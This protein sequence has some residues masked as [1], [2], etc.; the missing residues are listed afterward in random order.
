MSCSESEVTSDTDRLGLNYFPLEV[1]DYRVYDVVETKYSVLGVTEEIYELKESVV[2]S[3]LNASNNLQYIIHRSTRANSTESWH[4]D[5]TWTAQKST[6][7]A[8][9]TENNVP[10]VKLSFPIEHKLEWDG[11]RLNTR[12]SETYW[13]D[14]EI[15]DTTLSDMVYQNIVKVIQSDR[16]E[17]FLGLENRSE[18]FAPD[19]GLIIK[20]STILKYCQT[21]CNAEKEIQSGRE[22]VMTL[23]EYGKE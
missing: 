23:K 21:D 11:N 8:V 10:F 12:A 20:E 15:P 16:G 6:S 4:L 3:N 14:T 18:T 5:S 13:Y 2:D 22:I 9:L 19:A 7:I 17:D 1:G